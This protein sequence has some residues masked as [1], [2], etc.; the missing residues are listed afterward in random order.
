[1]VALVIS[2]SIINGC[3]KKIIH[4][5]GKQYLDILTE[6]RPDKYKMM[7]LA[8]SSTLYLFYAL[9]LSNLIKAV[10]AGYAVKLPQ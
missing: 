5:Q 6:G 10:S 9:S 7:T 8:Y 2:S 4:E 3:V 1:L